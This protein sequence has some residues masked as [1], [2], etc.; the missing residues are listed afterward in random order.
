MSDSNSGTRSPNDA[1]GK[2]KRDDNAS[3][4]GEE[5][6]TKNVALNHEVPEWYR[7]EKEADHAAQNKKLAGVVEQFDRKIEQFDRK[8]AALKAEASHKGVTTN[9]QFYQLLDK[10]HK[11]TMSR[12]G[13]ETWNRT[14]Q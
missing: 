8:I 2:R 13:E 9:A 1:T 11:L 3:L 10:E 12:R 7:K 14:A 5:P 6:V 4:E